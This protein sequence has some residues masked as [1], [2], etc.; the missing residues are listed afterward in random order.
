MESVVEW[1]CEPSAFWLVALLIFSRFLPL[2][3]QFVTHTATHPPTTHQS[4]CAQFSRPPTPKQTNCIS[5]LRL[6]KPYMCLFVRRG[7][8]AGLTSFYTMCLFMHG[9]ILQCMILVSFS[10]G[11]QTHS[12]WP[13]KGYYNSTHYLMENAESFSLWWGD[14]PL[15]PFPAHPH[16]PLQLQCHAGTRFT[17]SRT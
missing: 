8:F 15:S 10:F 4:F 5:T 14:V 6:A 9:E 11:Q 1:A 2:F 7:V 13:C 16:T 3:D 12:L 17:D